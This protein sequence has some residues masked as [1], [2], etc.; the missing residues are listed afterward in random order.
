V[1][2]LIVSQEHSRSD[3]DFIRAAWNDSSD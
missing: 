2:R 1:K 3:Q